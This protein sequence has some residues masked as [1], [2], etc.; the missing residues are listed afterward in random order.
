MEKV[1]EQS[2]VSKKGIMVMGLAILAFIAWASFTAYKWV[3]LNTPQ[4]SEAFFELLLIVI[5]YERAKPKY[6]YEAGKKILRITKFGLFGTEVYEVP[7][8]DIFGIYL[9]KPQ[10][11]RAVKFRR[12]Y[13][14]NSALDGRQVWTIAYAVPGKKGKPEN[15]RIYFKPSSAMLEFLQE[16]LPNKVMVTEEQVVVDMLKRSGELKKA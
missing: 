13:R 14:L 8:K 9:F 5:M 3:V 10:L 7:Y 6:E 16:K 11:V 2:V 4:I 1:V 12:T 15:R